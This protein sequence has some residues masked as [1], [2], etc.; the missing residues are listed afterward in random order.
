MCA[1]TGQLGCICAC[2]AR[3]IKAMEKDEAGAETL[4]TYVKKRKEAQRPKPR[5]VPSGEQ[6]LS[7]EDVQE[8][9]SKP[10]SRSSGSSGVQEDPTEVP[11]DPSARAELKRQS[12]PVSSSA[13]PKVKSKAAPPGCEKNWR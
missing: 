10:S 7:V 4:Q 9:Q 13:P 3:I 6:D 2:T 8:H 1:S 11:E 12:M 5:V